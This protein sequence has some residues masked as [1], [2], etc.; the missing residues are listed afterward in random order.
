MIELKSQLPSLWLSPE[1][2]EIIYNE[3]K[4]SELFPQPLP[5]FSTRYPTRLES[6]LGSVQLGSSLLGRNLVEVAVEYFFK[7]NCGHPFQNGNKRLSILYT[8]TFLYL[9]GY[10]LSIANEDL[11]SLATVIAQANK[12]GLE[13][14]ELKEI[15]K[16]IFLENLLI[17]E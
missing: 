7:I 14:N 9:N 15:T 17:I 13:E 5:D 4:Q 16:E 3:F 2:C 12:L 8:D 10:D 1:L 11:Y 6:I